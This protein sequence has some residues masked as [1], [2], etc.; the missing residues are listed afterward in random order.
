VDRQPRTKR[1]SAI[2]VTV[3]ERAALDY[4]SRYTTSAAGL[5][6]VLLR[7]VERAVRREGSDRAEGTAAV[8]TV[9]EKLLRLG[10]LNDAAF[11]E[12][13]ARN[14]QARGS[15]GRA[16]VAHLTAKGLG[17]EEIAQAMARRSEEGPRDPELAA[18]LVYCRK[19]RIGPYRDPD[20][21]AAARQRD[22]AAL[23]RRGFAYDVVRRVVE[24][25]D[26]EALKQEA[27]GTR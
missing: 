13:K 25:A 27:S 6:R 20:D 22:M 3:L 4:L 14:L 9:I 15:S 12:A 21:R 17:R 19:R 7:R 1:K 26:P 23:A 5:R 11:A 24:A 16:I 10:L 8:E 18:A 2:D